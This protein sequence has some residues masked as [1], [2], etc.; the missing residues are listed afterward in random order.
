MLQ[1]V[2]VNVSLE[3][4]NANVQVM[5]QILQSG[6]TRVNEDSDIAC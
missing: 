2:C 4:P 5:E 6:N 3:A 1:T